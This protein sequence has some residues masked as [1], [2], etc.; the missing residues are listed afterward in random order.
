MCSLWDVACDSDIS[1]DSMQ[2][3][4]GSINHLIL[5]C[6][7]AQSSG[8]LLVAN[9][10]MMTASGVCIRCLKK[11]GVPQDSLCPSIMQR[12][13]FS[14]TRLWLAVLTATQ[15]CTPLALVSDRLA[16]FVLYV[17]RIAKLDNRMHAY[18][19]DT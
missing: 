11:S 16:D 19:A 6:S 17:F 13:T 10:S 15:A 1:V 5:A 18:K 8:S 3:F 2:T 4:L 14:V 7:L 9:R 12:S